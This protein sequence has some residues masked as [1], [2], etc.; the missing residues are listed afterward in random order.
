ML[1]ADGAIPSRLR[2]TPARTTS[3]TSSTRRL[4][5]QP[6]GVMVEQRG[7]VRLVKNNDYV[8]LSQDAV[9]LHASSHYF[10]AATFEVWG[11]LLNGRGWCCIRARRWISSSSAGSS[12]HKKITIAWMTARLFDQFVAVWDKPLPHFEISAGRRRR[13]VTGVRPPR[14]RAPSGLQLVNGYGPTENTT[15]STC[16]AIPRDLDEASP[17]PHRPAD[18]P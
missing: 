15:F 5:G 12:T 18:P 7:V 16:Y 17:D 11:A 9:L 6:K 10:D 2:T 13:R 14:Q 4:H 8:P 1:E 3:H